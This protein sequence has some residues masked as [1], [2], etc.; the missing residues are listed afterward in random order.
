MMKVY[1][2]SPGCGFSDM[3]TA[4]WL[5]VRAECACGH[6]T[7]PYFTLDGAANALIRHQAG[8]GTLVRGQP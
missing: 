4:W 3:R 2:V 8:A 1:R 5:L 6:R 7:R